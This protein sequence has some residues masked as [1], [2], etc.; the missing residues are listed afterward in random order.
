MGWGYGREEQHSLEPSYLTQTLVNTV[1]GSYFHNVG[2]EKL[3]Y[4]C[5][6][7]GNTKIKTEPWCDA[8]DNL[9]FWGDCHTVIVKFNAAL[10]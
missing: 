3:K 5:I 4:R 10:C 2:E 9:L 7:L 6:G 8:C 1:R